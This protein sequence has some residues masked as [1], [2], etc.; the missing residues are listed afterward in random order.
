MSYQSINPNDGKIIKT[1]TQMSDIQL[2]SA[3]AAAEDCFKNWRD[4]SFAD[5]ATVAAKAAAIMRERVD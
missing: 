1:F 3:I 4:V 5:R 2:E